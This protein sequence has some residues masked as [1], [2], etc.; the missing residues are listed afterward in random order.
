MPTLDPAIVPSVDAVREAATHVRTFMPPSR[1][2]R[3]DA[4]ST[5]TG[6]DVWLKLELENP[7]GSFKVRGAYNVLAGLS[8]AERRAGVVASSAGNHGLGVA[9]AA[10]AFDTPAMLYVP[11]TAPQ[12]KKDGIR[13]LGAVVND[14]A[15]DYDAAM[16]LAKAH[17]VQQGIRFI[18]PCLGLDLLA[19]QGTVA[20]EVLEQLPSAKTVLICTGGGGLLGG[21]G[22]VLR[23][24]A[25]HVRIIGVQSEE[26]AAMTKSVHA[27]HVVDSP[28]TPTLAD[29]LAGQID[30]DALHIGQQCADDMVLVTEAELGETIAW[31]HR[32]LDLKVE[33]AGA[34][35]VAALRH[36]RVASL[37]GPVVAV[38]SGRNIDDSRLGALL[39][40]Y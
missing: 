38:V 26:T 34:V 35:T 15:L 7:T 6:V 23:A 27:G 39:A 33:G 2:E 25:P 4:L 28:V 24:L 36:G 9:Y 10:K 16:V 21:M 11:R 40:T 12:V 18:N 30:A 31:L 14:E 20:L 1:L 5:E 13:M 8:A 17:A 37:E 29:G 19:G 32:T 22:A 3:S